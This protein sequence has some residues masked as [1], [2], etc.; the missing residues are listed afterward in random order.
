MP[1]FRKPARITKQVKAH[2][3]VFLVLRAPLPQGT[4]MLRS[5]RLLRGM[6]G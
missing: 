5:T 1:C 2:A 6:R 4:R 3:L